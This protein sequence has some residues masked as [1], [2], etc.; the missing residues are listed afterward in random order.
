L[1]SEELQG[2]S[3][4][5]SHTERLWS[6]MER[7]YEANSGVA[8]K[9]IDDSFK[10][11]VRNDPEG[12]AGHFMAIEVAIIVEP[13]DDILMECVNNYVNAAGFDSPEEQ[14]FIINTFE[15]DKRDPDA[16]DLEE[17]MKFLNDLQQT[18]ICSCGKRFITDGKDM[19]VFCDLI[20]T[21]E[22]LQT[23]ECPVCLEQC[24]EL[25]SHTMKCCNHKIHLLCDVNWYKKGNKKCALCR[26]ELPKRDI[27]PTSINLEELVANIAEEVER[28][29]RAEE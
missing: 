22:K 2:M 24:K 9:N 10:I 13:D 4:M 15:F 18:I 1:L 21:P 14:E 26:A 17:F 6:A 19:C 28:R 20:A 7:I 27:R 29:S 8:F 23:F 11:L 12:S 3:P 5:I 25:H 16:E